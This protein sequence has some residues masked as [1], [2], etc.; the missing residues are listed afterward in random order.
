MNLL[1]ACD[2]QCQK[3]DWKTRHKSICGK[4]LTLQDAQAS[5]IGQE[6]PKQAWNIGQ[7]AVR[8]SLLDIPWVADI[9]KEKQSGGKMVKR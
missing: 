1:I 3:A 7:E 9:V 6:P 4:P 2:R 8:N 5:A